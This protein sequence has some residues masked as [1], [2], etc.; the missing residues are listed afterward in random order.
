V[1]RISQVMAGELSLEERGGCWT[2]T[3]RTRS[4]RRRSSD[5]G[6]DGQPRP[7]G[8]RP[9]TCPA[10]APRAAP[11]TPS[12]GLCQRWT[13]LGGMVPPSS[14][15]PT[16]RSSGSSSSSPSAST[17]PSRSRGGGPRSSSASGPYVG[18]EQYARLL[19]CEGLP[20]IR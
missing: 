19:A 12:C 4:P 11:S 10:R 14:S 18:G 6:P 17:S 20:P 15:C 9:G 2:R 1:T 8:G 3:S 7:A 5:P 13:G 16:W